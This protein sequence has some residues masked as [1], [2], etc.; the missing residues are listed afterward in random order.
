MKISR[1]G[2]F[3]LNHLRTGKRKKIYNLQK[4]EQR[5]KGKGLTGREERDSDCH[6]QRFPF[7]LSH[8][9]GLQF[10]FFLILFSHSC[11]PLK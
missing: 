5:E 11:R 6:V 2:K 4:K 3:V 8:I 9:S 7:K 10:F 1:F